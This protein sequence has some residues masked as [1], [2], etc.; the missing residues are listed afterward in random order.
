MVT[1]GPRPRRAEMCRSAEWSLDTTF[2]QQ[3][4][5][6]ETPF[7][8]AP[9][10]PSPCLAHS[11]SPFP[12]PPDLGNLQAVAQ[13]L[14]KASGSVSGTAADLLTPARMVIF[15]TLLTTINKPMFAASGAVYAGFGAS[16]TASTGSPLARSSTA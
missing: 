15:G 9:I 4:T 12:P 1:A 16:A 7:A 3:Q 11:P 8:Q 6:K 14:S 13:F 2:R 10:T 5:W